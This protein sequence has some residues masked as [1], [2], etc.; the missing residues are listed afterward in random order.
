MASSFLGRLW[1]VT[2]AG[3]NRAGYAAD[4]IFIEDL[5]Y[6]GV[7]FDDLF[8]GPVH[9]ILHFYASLNPRIVLLANRC[10]DLGQGRG[11]FGASGERDGD[12]GTRLR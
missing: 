12:A 1:I 6:P 4:V 9:E 7:L 8:N 3:G 11:A 5:P 10:I 2:Q